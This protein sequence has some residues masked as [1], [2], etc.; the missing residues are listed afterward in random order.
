MLRVGLNP[1]GLSYQLGLQGQGT[2][3]VEIAYSCRLSIGEGTGL[4]TG[5]LS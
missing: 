2:P 4:G 3:R 5:D 1:Y